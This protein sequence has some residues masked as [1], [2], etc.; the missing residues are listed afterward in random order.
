MVSNPLPLIVMCTCPDQQTA[1]MLAREAV[2]QQ[3]A[4]CVNIIGGVTSVFAWQGAVENE[5]E[6][7]LLA[8]TSRDAYAGLEALWISRHPYELPEVIAVPIETGSDAYLRW[9]EQAVTP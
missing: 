9:I 5:Q 4:A 2:T 1:E 7:L 6:Y 3:L 8:K